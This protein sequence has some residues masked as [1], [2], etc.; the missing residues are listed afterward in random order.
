LSS[1]QRAILIDVAQFVGLTIALSSVFA[2]FIIRA[3]HMS[4]GRSLF[5]RGMMWSPGMA[6]LLMLRRRGVSWREIGWTWTG[7]W[8]W[9]SFVTVI[10][11]GVFVYALAWITGMAGFPD[12]AAVE[13]IASDFGWRTMPTSFIVGGYAALTM[14]LGMVPAITSAL[15]EEIGWRGYLVP[16]LASGYSFT[17]T[18]LTSGCIWAVW[19]YPMFI[20]VDYDR[21]GQVWYSLVCFTMLLL[22]ASVICAWLRLKTGS[23]WPAVIVHA[24]NNLLVQDVLRPLSMT[25]RWSHYALDQFGGLLPLLAVM[26]A[27]VVWQRRGE[28]EGAFRELSA[29]DVQPAP[30]LTRALQ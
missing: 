6:A 24:S 25:S 26:A 19:H 12:P 3:G 2:M 23:I 5:T 30:V 22:A 7:R 18:A 16:R 9:I 4:S 14:T 15:G 10:L 8:E 29:D 13:S 27:V 28:V 21:G 20:V 11:G 17:S 1:R